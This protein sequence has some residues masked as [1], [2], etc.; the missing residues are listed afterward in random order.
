MKRTFKMRDFINLFVNRKKTI[1]LV[2]FY[3]TFIGGFASFAIP[4]KFEAKTEVVVDFKNENVVSSKDSELYLINTYNYLMKNNLIVNKVNGLLNETYENDELHQKVKIEANLNSKSLTILVKERTPDKAIALSN[5]IATTFEEEIGTLM[6]L[7]NVYILR[8][9]T[10]MEDKKAIEPI[11]VLFFVTAALL[12]FLVSYLFL[13]TQEMFFT[14]IDSP[15]KAEKAL[16]IPIIGVIPFGEEKFINE[17]SLN[18]VLSDRFNSIFTDLLNI[19]SIEKSTALLVTS[20]NSGDGKSFVSVNLSIAFAQG[21]KNTVYVDASLRDE[22][23]PNY[24][25]LPNDLGL[26]SYLS[27]LAQLQDIIQPTK[28]PKLSFISTG[29]ISSNPALLLSST[30]FTQLMEE[31]KKQFDI[32]IIDTPPLHFVDALLITSNVDACLYVVNSD[33]SK[34]EQSIYSIERLKKVQAPLI[35]LIINKSNT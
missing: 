28:V 18:D 33:S 31:L 10:V 22:A 25:Q 7:N 13:L 14:I 30:K 34:L 12:G 2:T 26:T 20:A 24:F 15:Q 27:G 11:T 3:V 32:I 19:L 35:R 4:P 21:L 5:T 23:G 16:G 17:L 29:P 6:N 1:L 9:A 8:K